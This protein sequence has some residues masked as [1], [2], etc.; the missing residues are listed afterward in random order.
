[1]VVPWHGPGVAAK[2]QAAA[3]GSGPACSDP[4]GQ[5]THFERLLNGKGSWLDAKQSTEKKMRD[6][7]MCCLQREF[8]GALKMKGC[9]YRASRLGSSDAKFAPLLPPLWLHSSLAFENGYYT[10][11]LF[12]K[13]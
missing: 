1:M 5:Q 7:K 4:G 3:E 9:L 13:E 2:G 10:C 8:G 12:P 11:N 6:S